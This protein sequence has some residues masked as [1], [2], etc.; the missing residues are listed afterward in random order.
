MGN[1]DPTWMINAETNKVPFKQ[2]KPSIPSWKSTFRSWP[3]KL[4][5]YMT[6][7]KRITAAKH[8]HLEEI[9]ISQ[10]ITLSLADTKKNE[11][12]I[13]AATYFWSSTL[14]AFMFKQGPM[15]P[16][17]IDVKMLTGLDIL[18]E[19]NPFNLLINSSHKLKTKKI[20]GWSRYIA[21]HM[22]QGSVSKREHVAFL[23]LWL[24]RFIF[25]G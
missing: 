16:T 22:E 21:E 15:T 18:T 13:S 19:I 23:T 8:S 24:E 4:N 17:L 1:S 7:Y 3:S 11:P 6:W 9:G 14:N 10:C 20:G 25:C 5:G 2:V 12:L